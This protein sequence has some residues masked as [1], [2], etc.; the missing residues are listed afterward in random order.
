MSVGSCA[1]LKLDERSLGAGVW[2]NS[3]IGR[4]L[5][6]CEFQADTMHEKVEDCK[7]ELLIVIAVRCS[8]LRVSL[9]TFEQ[10]VKKIN[11]FVQFRDA[12]RPHVD[13]VVAKCPLE[14]E[15]AAQRHMDTEETD[16]DLGEVGFPSLVALLSNGCVAKR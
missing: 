7:G 4:R 14:F 1:Q 8:A 11:E 6:Y 2:H 5:R 9:L 15:S 10:I 16:I 3:N 12:L 13:V